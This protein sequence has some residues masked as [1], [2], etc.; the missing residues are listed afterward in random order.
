MDRAHRAAVLRQSL[1]GGASLRGDEIADRPAAEI[2]LAGAFGERGIDARAL[3]FH[4]HRHHGE[5]LVARS[6]DEQLQL[7]VL[8]DRPECAERR[9]APARLAEALGPELHIPAREAFEPIGISHQHRDGPACVRRRDVERGAKR[10]RDLV[11]RIACEDRGERHP[12]SG[13]EGRD[14]EAEDRGG[15]QPNIAQA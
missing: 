12:G 15:Q 13:P 7:R 9:R 3:P 6:G 8:V 4:R 5:Q 10:G 11:R 2:R 1:G 14:V